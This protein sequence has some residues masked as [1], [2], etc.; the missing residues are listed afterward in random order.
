MSLNLHNKKKIHDFRNKVMYSLVHFSLL[1]LPCFFFSLF[2]S[3]WRMR[4]YACQCK[5]KIMFL[6]SLL[7]L[8]QERGFRH[9]MLWFPMTDNF[10]LQN[11][12]R[13][14]QNDNLLPFILNT[15]CNGL[16]SM[17]S[18]EFEFYYSYQDVISR[19]SL[20]TYIFQKFA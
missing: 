7:P 2:K 9:S 5:K 4:N 11:R 10:W 19:V 12:W 14:C 13:V 3:K 15:P 6:F 1:F 8:S 16:S 17:P 20:F 18:L